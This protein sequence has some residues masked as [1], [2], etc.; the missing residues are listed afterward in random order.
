[1]PN[2]T[3]KPPIYLLDSMAFIFRAYHAMQRSRPMSTRTGIPTAATY[4]FVNMINKLRKDFQPQ[5][6]AAVYDV[7]APLLRNEQAKQMKDVQKFNIK[8]Q[9]FETIEY[10]G[11]KA[12]RAETPPDL[13]QQQ[14]YIRRALEAF[15]IPILFYEGF[16]ADDV[17]GTLSCQLSALGHH[18]YVV[19]S[20]KD[21][22]QLVNEDVSILNPMKDNLILDPAGVENVLGVPPARVVDV[23][24]LRGDAIDN[25][26][27]APGIGDKGSVELIQQFGTVE[28][29]LD[30]AAEVKKKTYRES[31]QNNRDNILLSKELVTIHTAVPIEFSLDHMRT[32]PVDNAACRALFTELE[33]TT[34]LK[35]LAPDVDATPVTYNI[36]ATADDLAKLLAEAREPSLAAR[37]LEARS[38]TANQLPRGLAIALAETTQAI[39]EEVAADP[40]ASAEV[41]E[42]E[43]EPP[44]TMSLFGADEGAGDRAQGSGASSS[45]LL[46][47]SPEPSQDPA[48]RLG[49]AVTAGH[50]IEISLD[51]P[52]IREALADPALPKQV[53]DLKAV[54]RALQPHDITLAGPITDVMLQSY[55][56]NPTH[57]SHTLID[58]AA[59]TTSRAL[60]HQPTKDNPN[61]PKRLPEAAAAIARLAVTLGEQLAEVP[62]THVIPKDDPAL[63]GAITT[64]MLFADKAQVEG[65]RAQGAA[66]ASSGPLAL[67]PEASPL[68]EHST[69][70]EVYEQ[71]DL[72][73]VSVLLQMEQTG[74]RVDSNLLREMSS[75]LAVTIDD[76]AERI[77]ASSGHRF[78]INSPKQLGD[79]LFNKMD[80]PKPMKHGKGK[81]ISTAQ[82][83]LEDLAQHHEVPAI[84]LEYRQLQKLKSTYLDQLP[85][86]TDVNGRIHTTFNQV[87]TAT[88]RLS[89]INPNLQNIPIRTAVGREIRAAFIAAPG[90]LLMSAD[91]SQIELR[92]MAHFSQ[93]PL[94]L[95]AYRTGKDIHTL[96]AAEVFEVDAATMDKETRARAKAVNFG[97]VYGI[98]PFG[99][100]AQLGIDQ[101]VAKA[102]IER[103]FDR[104]KGVA[105]FIEQTLETVRRDQAVK[106]AFG[107]VRPIPDIQSRN[108]NQRGFAERTAVNTPLQGTA[109]DLIK[110]AMLRIDAAI[111]TRNLRSLMT[112]Q[113]H[114][115]LLFDVVPEEADEMQELVKTEM[116]SAAEFSVP[117]VAEVGLGDNWRDIK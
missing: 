83:I 76:L 32:Q 6:L 81:V 78:N 72:P 64:E 95:D 25:I 82:D 13:I 93:D 63:G 88:G 48:C 21:M 57:S 99:L 47:L 96:T 3:D 51:T 53:H 30:R 7:G 16:E 98:S 100:A 24:A 1:M 94:L 9:E 22:M 91:Y 27:G 61:D 34:M 102:Y 56:L 103:Y 54:L 67:N 66:S 87:G 106:T 116:E 70:A 60:T 84:V 43:P 73:L 65:A 107:R 37:D 10:G 19:S 112:L 92:L 2:Q 101:K 15:R 86:L 62:T 111:R 39:A 45:E 114:D 26:P 35:E 89:S 71:L 80:L 17:I 105:T 29:A 38:S 74:V 4:V 23:M 58:L 55:L 46:A 18:V 49:L 42:S 8:T 5:Y 104:Y 85:S 117:I 90:N 41:E 40:S 97:I 108:P 115:E 77:Y 68:N 110:I 109:A 52:G 28:G 14:P 75:R 59:R 20:D 33:F 31:L 113:V 79:V 12:N 44:Q 50:A 69:L 11:Y 36:K